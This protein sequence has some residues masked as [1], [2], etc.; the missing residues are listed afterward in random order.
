MYSWGDDTEDWA[1]P[2]SYKF[3]KSTSEI[4][5]KAKSE[6]ESAGGRTY[7][8]SGGPVAQMIDA[9]KTIESSSETV[10]IIGVDV[11]GSMASWP[12][13]IFDRLPLLYQTLSQYKPDLEMAFGAI[14]DSGCDKWPLQVTDFALGFTLENT[15][16][17]LYGEGGGG[18]APESYGLFAWWMANHVKVPAAKR[19]FLIVFGDAEMHPTIPRAHI[20]RLCGDT[21]PADPTS[22]DAWKA[23]A[24][25]FDVWFLRRPT[26]RAGDPI[27]KQWVAALGKD[28]VVHIDDEA[29]A[30]D[31]AMGIVARAWGREADF[32][33][34]M[35]ARQDQAKVEKVMARLRGLV[36]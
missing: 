22:L 32:E 31:Y 28:R 29:R 24:K 33:A 23:V 10:V 16:K 8:K 4:R 13:E 14:G 26:G 34:N 3:D 17:A 1:K 15:L 25:V 27:E 9:H 11:T 19:P 36:V 6:S 2:G 7:T 12:A 35:L 20:E 18:D 30:V 5:E 21:V